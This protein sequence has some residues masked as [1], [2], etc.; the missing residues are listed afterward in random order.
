MFIEPCSL[1]K[2]IK[3]H[4]AEDVMK[5]D[6]VITNTNNLASSVY[7][8]DIIKILSDFICQF[9]L[10]VFL[11]SIFPAPKMITNFPIS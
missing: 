4:I 6:S 10:S 11:C 9:L 5:M 8:I 2:T 3:A 1:I 7:I